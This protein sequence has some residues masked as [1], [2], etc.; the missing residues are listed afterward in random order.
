M[1]SKTRLRTLNQLTWDSFLAIQTT[2][3][4]AR[5]ERLAY[6]ATMKPLSS[7]AEIAR[8]A[9]TVTCEESIVARHMRLTK[10]STGSASCVEQGY[11]RE[12]AAILGI[13]TVLIS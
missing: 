1:G 3:C 5:E 13:M 6:S 2:S 7:V 10:S 11:L 8:S 12:K 4:A 9:I